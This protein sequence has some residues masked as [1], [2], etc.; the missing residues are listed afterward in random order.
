MYL[1]QGLFLTG[2]V[3]ALVLMGQDDVVDVLLV[4]DDEELLIVEDEELLCVDDVSLVIVDV[5]RQEQAEERR[6]GE[7]A[8]GP[9]RAVGVGEGALERLISAHSWGWKMKEVE[10]KFY[11]VANCFVQKAVSLLL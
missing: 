3:A 7:L 1:Q 9:E 5:T 10:G 11:V 6:E 2:Q 8:Q 4:V